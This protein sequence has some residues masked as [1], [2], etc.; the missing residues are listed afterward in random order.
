MWQRFSTGVAGAA[1]AATIAMGMSVP[2]R[3][4]ALA[5]WTEP[6]PPAFDLP[7]FGAPAGATFR[8]SG[9]RGDAILVHFFASWCEPCRDELPA[10]KRLS[11]RGA[12]G[13]TVV[14]IAVADNDSRLRRLLEETGVTFPVLVDPDRKVARAWSISALPSTVILDSRHKARLIVESDVAWDTLE[15]KQLIDR[16]SLPD[17]D[18]SQQ[19]SVTQGG[20]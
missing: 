4:A 3:G 15:P 5:P 16:L 14:A 1:I 2:A 11:D 18:A 12:P 10:L 7:Q 6:S 8:L 17:K 13:L 9:Q 20:H 19:S